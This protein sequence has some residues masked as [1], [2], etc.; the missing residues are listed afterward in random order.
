MRAHRGLL[1]GLLLGLAACAQSAQAAV[2]EVYKTPTCGCCSAWVEHLRKNGFT[3]RV[4]DM[5]DVTPV[6][7]KLGVPDD[8]RSC[9]TARAGRYFVEGH[10]PASDVR[11]LLKEQPS[12]A[13][14]AVP[15]MP[16]GSPGMEQGGIKDSFASLIVDKQGKA[17]LFV[18]H[19]AG[20]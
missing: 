15:G 13:G 4:T 17:K 20:Q 16:S 7:R 1:A 12:A 5:D 14:I 19:P 3:V 11:K 8:L 6:A 10:V 9:H 18:R 2:I